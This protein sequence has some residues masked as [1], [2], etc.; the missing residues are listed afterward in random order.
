MRYYNEKQNTTEKL[1][2]VQV[3]AFREKANAERL[4]NELKSKGY[5]TYI[6]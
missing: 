3:G 5:S 6:V 2:K 1:Y 4:A